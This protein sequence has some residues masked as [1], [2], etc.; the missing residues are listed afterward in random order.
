MIISIDCETNSN[1]LDEQIE[2]KQESF[3]GELGFGSST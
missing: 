3:R 1:L 2:T